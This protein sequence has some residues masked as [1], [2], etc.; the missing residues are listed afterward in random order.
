M[1]K[2]NSNTLAAPSRKTPLISLD[3]NQTAK[4][5]KLTKPERVR[6]AKHLFDTARVI[7]NS[8]GKTVVVPCSERVAKMLAHAVRVTGKSQSWLINECL[9]RHIKAKAQR[10][11]A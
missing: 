7:G 6:V 9:R 2:N 3:E 11:A 1:K 8:A 10:L 4:I 5:A